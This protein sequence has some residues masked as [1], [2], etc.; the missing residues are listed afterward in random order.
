MVKVLALVCE[1]GNVLEQV[2]VKK[3]RMAFFSLSDE[4]FALASLDT[5]QFKNELMELDGDD[6]VKLITELKK[7][8]DLEDDHMEMLIEEGADLAQ[9]AVVMLTKLVAF[10]Q[11]VKGA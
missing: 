5:V 9:D 3:K 6:R 4:M 7:K 11:K 8:L 10:Y 2:L 1:L